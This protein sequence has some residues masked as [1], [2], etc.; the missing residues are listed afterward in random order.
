MDSSS[1]VGLFDVPK[2]EQFE[3]KSDVPAHSEGMGWVTVGMTMI[4][5][6]VGMG[7][8]TM[9]IAFSQL[10][11]V[12]ALVLLTLLLPLNI[13]MGIL[14]CEAR[15]LIPDALSYQEMAHLAI[16]RKWFTHFVN[17]SFYT[18]LIATLGGYILA[19]TESLKMVFFEWDMCT[20]VIGALVVA[21]MIL[22]VQVRSL[23]DAKILIWMNFFMINFAV[24]ASLGYMLSNVESHVS[25][26]HVQTYVLPP[27]MSAMDFFNGLSKILFAYLGCYIYLEIMREMKNPA[28]FPKAFLIAAPYQWSMYVFVG[29][30][31]FIY[32]GANSSNMI[33]KEID[34]RDQP[35][36]FRLVAIALFT[37]LMASYLIKATILSRKFHVIIS[38]ETVDKTTMKARLMW[39]AITCGLLLVC[40]LIASSIPLFDKIT[41][42]LGGLLAPILGYI[43]PIV[44]VVGARRKCSMKTSMFQGVLFVGMI[45]F[46]I[47]LVFI[48]TYFNFKSF[49]TVMQS[50]GTTPFACEAGSY[51]SSLP[52]LQ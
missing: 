17:G 16:G 2:R 15:S 49:I 26:F 40:Y 7:I 11:W 52:P 38:P 45:V 35:V 30:V 48:G 41:S 8:L 24:F 23:Q 28:E 27:N 4:G 42:I 21:L 31:G 33:I 25:L 29:V 50:T 18:Y 37:H 39:L 13:Y 1:R 36:L 44:F 12:L 46:M 9:A 20:P 10:G 22:P 19:L 34:P 47:V 6:V 32:N 14:L 51:V 43:F 5:D 3:D